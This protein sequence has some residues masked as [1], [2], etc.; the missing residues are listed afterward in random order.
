M[1]AA[2]DVF[3]SEPY[4]GPLSNINSCLLTSHMGSMSFDCRAQMEIEATQE[5]IRDINGETLINLVPDSSYD[6]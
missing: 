2:I 1:G 6:F 4:S 5:V 3:E